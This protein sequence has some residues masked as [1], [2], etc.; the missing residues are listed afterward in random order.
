MVVKVAVNF[1]RIN[2]KALPGHRPG[3][4]R[5]H[6]IPIELIY[7]NQFGALFARLQT[8]GFVV[9]DFCYNGMML[10]ANEPDAIRYSLPLH[11]GPHPH[12]TDLT[13]EAVE[14]VRAG[15]V[16]DPSIGDMH[17][18]LARIRRLQMTLQRSL[19]NGSRDPRFALS[20][21]DPALTNAAW[22]PKQPPYVI[23]RSHYQTSPGWHLR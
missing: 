11:R 14:A 13:A 8:L 17:R 5:H 23:V 15:L 22:V 16:G 7:R 2:R 6:L 20:R 18:A 1:S 21:R 19:T 12:Y 9:H 10:P 4:Q 3:W